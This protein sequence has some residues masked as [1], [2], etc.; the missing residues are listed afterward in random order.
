MNVNVYVYVGGNSRFQKKRHE[1]PMKFPMKLND[2]SWMC[3][4]IQILIHRHCMEFPSA[5]VCTCTHAFMLHVHSY[6]MSTLRRTSWLHNRKTM[7]P[8]P[9]WSKL[10][11][12]SGCSRIKH[13]SPWRAA[14]PHHLTVSPVWS[15]KATPSCRN[16]AS[17]VVRA[18]T[19]PPRRACA[20]IAHGVRSDRNCKTA[21]TLQ[22]QCRLLPIDDDGDVDEMP[23]HGSEARVGTCRVSRC[24]VDAQLVSC[25]ADHAER[26]FRRVF[27]NGMVCGQ[28][29]LARS[30]QRHSVGHGDVHGVLMCADNMVRLLTCR[31]HD[32]VTIPPEASSRPREAAKRAQRRYP[33]P[34]TSAIC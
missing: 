22:F 28:H 32:A 4:P 20:R 2:V 34:K 30:R 7:R 33:N 16:S 10:Q 17:P 5:Y 9:T 6:S 14:S 29:W 19:G 25:S 11:V 8:A 15:V 24:R 18:T 12:D 21:G 3:Y 31:P 23:T 13:A 26:A 27:V 1:K